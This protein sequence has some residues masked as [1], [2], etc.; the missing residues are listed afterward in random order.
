MPFFSLHFTYSAWH[1][2][3]LLLLLTESQQACAFSSVFHT[4]EGQCSEADQGGMSVS[5]G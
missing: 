4:V 1:L 3:S 5:N 2:V